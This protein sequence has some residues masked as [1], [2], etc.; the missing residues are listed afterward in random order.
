M[1][2]AMLSFAI[3]LHDVT[4]RLIQDF[5]CIFLLTYLLTYCSLRYL[6]I[7]PDLKRLSFM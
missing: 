6:L 1:R 5:T 7:L 3:R 2:G 4:L